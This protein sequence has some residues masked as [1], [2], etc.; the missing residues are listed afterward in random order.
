MAFSLACG[1]GGGGGGPGAGGGGG[2]AGGGA[3][4]AA[5]SV[6]TGRWDTGEGSGG[7]TPAL[8]PRLSIPAHETTCHA[9]QGHVSRVSTHLIPRSWSWSWPRHRTASR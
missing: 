7:L 6:M 1:G 8:E 4:A 3:P 5:S 9:A 2:G